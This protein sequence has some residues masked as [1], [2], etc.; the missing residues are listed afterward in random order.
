[1]KNYAVT[2]GN[3][4]TVYS[5]NRLKDALQAFREYKSQ[6]RENYGRAA[7]EEVVLWENGEPKYINEAAVQL[8]KDKI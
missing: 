6:S 5:G 1:M 8:L 3:I 4:G 2:V 7:G